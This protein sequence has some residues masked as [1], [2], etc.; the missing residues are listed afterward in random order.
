MSDRV[1]LRLDDSLKDSFQEIGACV[2]AYIGYRLNIPVECRHGR[3][4]HDGLIIV[5]CRSEEEASR[6]YELLAPN[7]GLGVFKK[8]EKV[9]RF[10]NYG[11]HMV[12]IT[13]LKWHDMFFQTMALWVTANLED[14]P[15]IRYTT[16]CEL[17]RAIARMKLDRP[18]TLPLREAPPSAGPLPAPLRGESS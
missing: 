9:I 2:I 8:V 18:R 3:E 11:Y 14:D 5:N 4:G 1:Y 16:G 17:S 15:T 12:G 10:A 13:G 6:I 7:E